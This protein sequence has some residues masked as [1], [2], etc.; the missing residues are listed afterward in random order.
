MTEW[1]IYFETQW[2]KYSIKAILE[3]K[4][5][6]IYEMLNDDD[7]GIRAFANACLENAIE[8]LL[9]ENEGK[10]INEIE[11]QEIIDDILGD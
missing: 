1:D 4:K 2:N 9:K 3:R 6:T 8:E 7:E 10:T 5:M 11:A